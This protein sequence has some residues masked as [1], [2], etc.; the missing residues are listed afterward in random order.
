MAYISA[1]F[2]LLVSIFYLQIFPHCY[3]EGSGLTPFKVGS[4]YVICMILFLAGLALFKKRNKFDATVSSMLTASILATVC[5]ELSITL[6]TDVYGFFNMLG[7]FLKIASFW[8]IYVAVVK[9]GLEKPYSMLFREL[10]QSEETCRAERD[11]AHEYFGLAGTMMVVIDGDERV[12]MVNQKACDILGYPENEVVGRNWFDAFLPER[13]RPEVKAIFKRL[14]DGEMET[15]EHVEGVI[16]TRRGEERIIIWHNAILKNDEGKPIGTLSSGRILLTGEG[17]K[18]CSKDLLTTTR[19]PASRIGHCST[20]AST[21]P[22]PVRNA[23][24]KGWRSW[25]STWTGS[26]K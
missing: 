17:P 11:R 22:S 23:R 24:G 6:Y 7:H 19:L 9:T 15:L 2:L 14:M 13:S 10:K 26:K 20:T 4:E 1:T 8:L 5:T 18:R 21:P 3:I 25:Y 12:S 16:V